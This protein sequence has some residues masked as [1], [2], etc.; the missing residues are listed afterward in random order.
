MFSITSS[1][2][3]NIGNWDT[4]SVKNMTGMFL[5]ARAFNKDISKW[6]VSNVTSMYGMFQLATAF[7]QDL[8][9]WNVSSS[10]PKNEMFTATDSLENLPWWYNVDE[11]ISTREFII[12]ADNLDKEACNLKII[13]GVIEENVF[14]DLLVFK[15]NIDKSTLLTSIK[16]RGNVSCEE[17]GR[18]D[19]LVDC[20]YQY[21]EGS[22]G[23]A[24]IIGLNFE[25]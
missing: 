6:D 8:D 15:K 21:I 11:D 22:L 14:S 12:V 5:G 2:N 18:E 13:K 3:K 16:E 7:N 20:S 4:S 9:S 25:K 23:E 1:F 19:Q 24:C 17:Y 10:V